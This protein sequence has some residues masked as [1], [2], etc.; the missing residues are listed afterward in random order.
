MDHEDPITMADLYPALTPEEQAEAMQ[1]LREYF[2]VVK[3]IYDGMSDEEKAKL[4]LRMQ[5]EKRTGS[6]SQNINNENHEPKST[7]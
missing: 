6:V 3:R 1:N 7:G 2:T 5:W 4:G